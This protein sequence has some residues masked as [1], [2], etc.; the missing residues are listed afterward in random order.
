MNNKKICQFLLSQLKNIIDVLLCFSGLTLSPGAWCA[1]NNDQNPYLQID[2]L[3]PHTITKLR[4]A[5]PILFKNI[6]CSQTVGTGPDGVR[7]RETDTICI[8]TSQLLET[9]RQLTET[10]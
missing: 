9:F 8:S 7:L 10:N 1:D 6:V 3:T 2:L 4:E 5:M